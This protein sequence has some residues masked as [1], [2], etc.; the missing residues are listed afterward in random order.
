MRIVKL[1]IPVFLIWVFYPLVGNKGYP[2][3]G[4]PP[5]WIAISAG[6]SHTVAQKS[7]GTL[8]AWGDNVYGQLGAGDCIRRYEPVQVGADNDWKTFSCGNSYTLAVKKDGTLW[9]WG[10]IIV[11]GY[12][13]DFTLS[14]GDKPVQIN[15]DA[16]W[17]QVSAGYGYALAIKTDGTLWSWGFD[18]P[19]DGQLGLG[20]AVSRDKPTQVGADVDWVDISC[21]LNHSAAIKKDGTLWTWGCNFACAL[22]LGVENYNVMSKTVPTLIT[23]TGWK[24]VSCGSYYT[25]AVKQDGTLWA[26]GHNEILGIEQTIYE[27]LQIGKGTN[28]QE[29]SAGYNHIIARKANGSIWGWGHGFQGQLGLSDSNNRKS[30]CQIGDEF[31]WQTISAG[32]EHT[33]AI[34][35]DGSIWV[36]G[37]NSAGQLGLMLQE[38]KEN[39]PNQVESDKRWYKV[40][41]GRFHSGAIDMSNKLLM[42]GD[43][44]FAQLGVGDNINRTYPAQVGQNADWAQISPGGYFTAALKQDGTLWGWGSNVDGELGL[45]K[46]PTPGTLTYSEP[47]RIDNSSDWKQIS[48]GWGHC[49]GIKQGGAILSWGNNEYGQLGWGDISRKQA[50]PTQIDAD[51]DW[52]YATA[53]WRHTI[54]LKQNGSLWGWGWNASGQVGIENDF[55]D[56]LIPCQI[57]PYSDWRFVSAGNEHTAAIKTDGTLWAWGRNDAGQLGLG[58]AVSR[59]TPT[60]VGT[61]K[62]WQIVACGGFHTLAI[63]TDGTLWGWGN[64]YSGELGLGDTDP[65]TSPVQITPDTNWDGVACGYCHTIAVKKDD[66]L[67]AWGFSRYG[68]LGIS[69]NKYAPTLL[70]IQ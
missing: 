52:L 50:T 12:K 62:D 16:Y 58:D 26:W 60:Q 42:W 5:Q 23:G 10:V 17:Q 15:N 30:P 21:F 55:K 8:W 65:K 46:P 40:F 49:V 2:Q 1:I 48:S 51:S 19:H 27:P 38:A 45:R 54:A 59:T 61:D 25:T 64:N 37:S 9:G 32:S 63:K 66:T 67:W 47:V 11:R 39:K 18:S 3:D 35:Q 53:G 36:W 24:S 20:D 31:D 44:S 7:D 70:M 34:K 41:A 56:I 13:G 6:W 69:L 33:A 57:G 68:Q 43:N 22:G 14:Y 29:I 4:L 28:W